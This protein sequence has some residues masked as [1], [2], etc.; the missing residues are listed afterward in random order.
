MWLWVAIAIVVIPTCLWLMLQAQ[1]PRPISAA[2][3]TL[4]I[5]LVLLANV[6]VGGLIGIGSPFV[7][8]LLW[9]AARRAGPWMN[10]VCIA[11]A[12][13]SATFTGALA[14]WFLDL[15]TDPF[16]TPIMTGILA[17]TLF[18]RFTTTRDQS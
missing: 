4:F 5:A 11:L 15:E 8:P 13:L 7:I 2:G 1:P 6:G 16:L 14:A 17:V 10:A 9:L 12:G 18:V 3:W